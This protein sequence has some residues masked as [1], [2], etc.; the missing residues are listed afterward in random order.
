MPFS[1][2]TSLAKMLQIR[3]AAVELLE[4]TG[5]PFWNHLDLTL[6]DFCRETGTVFA[7]FLKQTANLP[8]AA[9]DANFAQEPLYR[10]LDYLTQNHRD[11]QGKDLPEISHLLDVHNIPV[12]PDGYVLKLAHQ[13]FRAFEEKFLEH[14][15]EEEEHVFPHILRLEAAL[16]T[17]GL[18]PVLHRA[19][20][21]VFAAIQSHA[22]EEELKRMI[23]EVREKVR[24]HRLQEPTATVTDEVYRQLE[25]FEGRFSAHAAL[26]TGVLFPRAAEIERR[27]FNR[28]FKGKP[29]PFP[30]THAP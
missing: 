12:Y 24:N 18:K 13:T 4:K 19:S 29:L 17:P 22:A 3:P 26:E 30:L 23:A 20:V 15:R 7:A 1:E 27:L 21:S 14:M 10:L 9:P 5:K 25:S 28:E 2:S 6:A 16:R 11:F 8:I